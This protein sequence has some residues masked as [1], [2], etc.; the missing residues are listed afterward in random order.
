MYNN[1]CQKCFLN[2]IL[3]TLVCCTT[4][5][6]ENLPNHDS[7]TKG[8]LCCANLNASV[9]LHGSHDKFWFHYLWRNKAFPIPHVMNESVVKPALAQVCRAIR[10][11]ERTVSRVC[12]SI[13]PIWIA[14]RTPC[15][16]DEVSAH[17]HH[18]LRILRG[19]DLTSSDNWREIW[20]C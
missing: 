16:C 10:W 1:A 9:V 12:K 3:T 11:T 6:E 4:Q 13:G 15:H 17:V 2:V 18:S 5:G 14:Y 20:D 8:C 7:D 19:P